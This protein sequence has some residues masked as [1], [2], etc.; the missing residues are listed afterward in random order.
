MTNE[1][2]KDTAP[3]LLQSRKFQAV[4]V[5]VGAF[6]VLAWLA[7]GPGEI[8]FK[9]LRL[10]MPVE[11]AARAML[12]NGLPPGG[13]AKWYDPYV[14]MDPDLDHA[15]REYEEAMAKLAAVHVQR[16][17][18]E[19]GAVSLLA[20]IRGRVPASHAE[21]IPSMVS[22][23]ITGDD[24]RAYGLS[25]LR[26]AAD[27]MRE[28]A[29]GRG[30]DTLAAYLQQILPPEQYAGIRVDAL[31]AEYS[32]ENLE[33]MLL[34]WTADSPINIAAWAEPYG[35]PAFP[36]RVPGADLLEG[37]TTLD[38]AYDE[39]LEFIDASGG[40][41]ADSV[42]ERFAHSVSDYEIAYSKLARELPVSLLPEG[43]VLPEPLEF[44]NE[45]YPDGRPYAYG[46]PWDGDSELRFERD[47][48]LHGPG[49]AIAPDEAGNVAAVRLQ[50][51]AVDALFNAGDMSGEE[52]AQAFIDAYGIHELTASDVGGD[53]LFNGSHTTAQGFAQAFADTYGP[54]LNTRARAWRYLDRDAGALLSIY[55]GKLLTLTAVTPAE[56]QTFD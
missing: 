11:D 5:V 56:A 31:A 18:R 53:A 51:K 50:P 43:V 15:R 37:L 12:R 4:A 44:L 20:Y 17:M 25:L 46:G 3:G 23:L 10:G 6:I 1:E 21:F 34:R 26:R 49:W 14:V 33:D 47:G 2:K 32:L 16:A 42:P 27:A 36:G 48:T 41:G 9:G 28:D 35:L 19:S 45:R 38:Y 7:S 30:A 55:P 39:V 40:L 52:F 22:A 8:E 29:R 13:T 54:G 24:V